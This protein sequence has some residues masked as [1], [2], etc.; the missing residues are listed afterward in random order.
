MAPNGTLVMRLEPDAWQMVLVDEQGAAVALL[1]DTVSQFSARFSS[2]GRRVAVCGDLRRMPALWMYEV[3]TG[4]ISKLASENFVGRGGWVEWSAEG[5]HVVEGGVTRLLR[6]YS[7]DGQRLDT[8]ARSAPAR[9][10]FPTGALPPPPAAFNVWSALG[11]DVPSP[12]RRQRDG[13][14]LLAG[15]SLDCLCLRRIGAL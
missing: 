1:P 2:D 5:R 14:A 6:G 11:P 10:A 12:S 4:T 3:A 7:T 13:S 8:L 9:N 15:R